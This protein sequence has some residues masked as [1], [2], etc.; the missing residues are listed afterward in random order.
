MT[1]VVHAEIIQ[2]LSNLNLLLGIKESIGELFTFS[3][4]TFDNLETRDIAKEVTDWLIWVISLCWMWVLLG[5]N[6]GVSWMS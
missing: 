1:H 4:R 2:S 6:R 5:L 3:Q